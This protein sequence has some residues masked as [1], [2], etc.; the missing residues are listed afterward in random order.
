M[1]RNN[2]SD[3][4][5]AVGLPNGANGIGITQ[6]LSNRQ[7]AGSTPVGNLDQFLPDGSRKVGVPGEI[8]I[9]FK[10]KEL[11]IQQEKLVA[12]SKMLKK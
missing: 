4:V 8:Q 6:F 10:I 9:Q 3:G 2:N 11:E 1:A 5:I 12:F 7:I